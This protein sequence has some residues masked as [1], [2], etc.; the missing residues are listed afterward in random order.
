MKV[1][2]FFSRFTIICNIAFLLFIFLGK[3]EARKPVTHNVDTV[4]AVSYFKD[5]IITLGV[6]AIIINLLMCIVYSVIVILGRQ[7]ILPKRLA[8]INCLFLIF[9]I[10]YFFFR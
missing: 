3:M 4:T 5:I 7:K 8:V 10:F 9:Q 2:A 1:I 6:L